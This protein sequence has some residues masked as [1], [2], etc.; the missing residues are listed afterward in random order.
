MRSNQLGNHLDIAL[1]YQCVGLTQMY[2][3]DLQGAIE[4]LQK[5]SK[6]RK[7]LQ[8]FS[9]MAD[10]FNDLGCVHLERGDYQSAR[11]QFQDAV[12]LNKKFRG[13]HVNTANCCHNLASTYLPLGRYAEAL[14]VCQQALSMR[15]EFLGH[16][17][18]TLNSLETL[19][20][21]HLKMGNICCV[22]V[23]FCKASDIK[24]NRLKDNEVTESYW[25]DWKCSIN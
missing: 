12:D 10:I 20:C 6:L 1:S 3:G 22:Q 23:A 25:K 9:G 2:A 5:A 8:D 4:S 16:N 21:I 15:L 19:E 11:E 18:Q 14:D 24:R 17:E 7:R 13:K